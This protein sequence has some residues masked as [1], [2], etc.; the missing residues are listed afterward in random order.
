MITRVLALLCLV[1]PVAADTNRVL[2]LHV[3]PS[4]ARFTRATDALS[5]AGCAPEQLKPAFREAALAWGGMSHLAAPPIIDED[6][7]Q[8]V[9]AWPDDQ[10]AAVQ[11]LS[12]LIN[13]G[14]TAWTPEA[15]ASA[16]SVTRGLGALERLIW[17]AAAQP[18][19]LTDALAEDLAQT[20][21]RIQDTWTGSLARQMRRPAAGGT[22]RFQTD[23][24]VQMT[25]FAALIAGLEATSEGRL[26][27]PLADFDAPRPDLAELHRSDLSIPMVIAALN[28]LQALATVM[29]EAP[30][31]NAAFARALTTAGRI[32][33]DDLSGVTNPTSRVRIEALQTA[34]R[35]A[36]AQAQSEIGR[37][38]GVA[39][40][41][42][43]CPQIADC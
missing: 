30:G 24:E 27:R 22:T 38:L 17:D 32:E 35:D 33:G 26:G 29:S 42:S 2:D 13:Q 40:D 37:P 28:G 25:L 16:P 19:A 3:L 15:L 8:A 9:L 5:Q 10:M 14:P 18:C 23:R 36:L 4:V 43:V 39:V 41:G 21:R 34:V 31:T 1:S 12:R 7:G 20:A 11:D 6:L